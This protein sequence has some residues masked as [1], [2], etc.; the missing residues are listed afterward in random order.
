MD[1][2]QRTKIFKDAFLGLFIGFFLRVAIPLAI[3]SLV[4]IP[5]Y[6]VNI[7]KPTAV[8]YLLVHLSALFIIIL[9]VFLII[10]KRGKKYFFDNLLLYNLYFKGAGAKYYK[11]LAV[12]VVLI[13]VLA[14][15]L[16]LVKAF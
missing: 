11:L 10:K 12:A 2:S 13:I 1:K 14:L 6:F 8:I 15:I 9:T 5:S 4:F 7:N 16:A 3:L